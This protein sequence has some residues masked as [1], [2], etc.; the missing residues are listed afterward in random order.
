MAKCFIFDEKSYC[1]R[2][3]ILTH[4]ALNCSIYISELIVICNSED[5]LYRKSGTNI[6]CLDW[7]VEYLFIEKCHPKSHPSVKD[8]SGFLPVFHYSHWNLWEYFWL[9][10]HKSAPNIISSNHLHKN[11]PSEELTISCLGNLVINQ[12]LFSLCP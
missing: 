11:F 7:K 4:S 8:H 3:N 9:N 5:F 6:N 2:K 12:V 10:L 1:N